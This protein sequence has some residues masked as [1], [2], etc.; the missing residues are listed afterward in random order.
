[1]SERR[2]R[3]PDTEDP[4]AF[5]EPK[6]AA[7]L[8]AAEEVRWLL[9]RGYPMDLAVRAAGDHHQLHAR[10]RASRSPVLAAPPSASERGDRSARCPMN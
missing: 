1:M 4:R 5:A 7:L 6:R 3:G 9:G 8:R 2:R 10:A